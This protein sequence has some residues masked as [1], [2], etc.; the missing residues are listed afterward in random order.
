MKEQGSN[1]E[2]EVNSR[3]EGAWIRESEVGREELRARKKEIG[4]RRREEQKQK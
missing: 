4:V 2:L 1:K 3:E